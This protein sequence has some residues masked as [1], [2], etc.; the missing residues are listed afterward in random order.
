MAVVATAV[1]ATVHAH[2][3]VDSTLHEALARQGHDSH[4]GALAP[5]ALIRRALPRDVAI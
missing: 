4:A 3:V 5:S 1:P 2:A